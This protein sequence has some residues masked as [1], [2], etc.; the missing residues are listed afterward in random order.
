[1]PGH[2]CGISPRCGNLATPYLATPRNNRLFILF[3]SLV[4]IFFRLQNKALTVANEIMNVF[5][6]GDPSSVRQARKLAEEVF[7]EG[8]EA[9]GPEIYDEGVKRAQ[10]WGIGAWP[11]P[12]RR[13]AGC[14]DSFFSFSRAVSI[15]LLLPCLALTNRLT[16]CHI[17]TA[18]FVL[19]FPEFM[20]P[21]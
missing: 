16:S 18:W 13:T 15:I 8:W 5:K 4:K 21:Y 3:P 2:C 19:Q 7:G 12:L 10:I 17:D 9:K 11:V 6:N 14:T 20:K 1:M